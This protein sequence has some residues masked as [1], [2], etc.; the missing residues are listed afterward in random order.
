MDDDDYPTPAKVFNEKLLKSAGLEN[1][2]GE[3]IASLPDIPLQVPRGKYAL[4]FYKTYVRF[5]GRSQD[6]KIQ[7]KDIE[8][9]NRLPKLE[10]DHTL[11]LIVLKKDLVIGQTVHRYLLVQL[12]T[13]RDSK[14]RINMSPDEITAQYGNMIESEIQDETHQILA[15]LFTTIGG[16]EKISQTGDFRSALDSR[17]QNVSCSVKASQGNLFMLK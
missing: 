8:A 15:R 10:S 4:D 3:L 5:H 14:I 6:F 2:A 17:A 12:D 1:A 16:I 11:F 9:L 13:Q 7:Y